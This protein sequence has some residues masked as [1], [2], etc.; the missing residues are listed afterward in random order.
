MPPAEPKK[1]ST[2][3][4]VAIVALVVVVATIAVPV[5]LILGMSG[6]SGDTS[7]YTDVTYDDSFAL[8][9]GGNFRVTAGWGYVTALEIHMNVTDGAAVDVYIMTED[10]YANTYAGSSPLAYSAV[11]F[12]EN[13]T[14]LSV[15]WNLS[16]DAT[17]TLYVV[18]DNVDN[19]LRPLDAT[20]TGNVEVEMKLVATTTYYYD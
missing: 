17:S 15:S 2:T 18:V 14:E 11:E 12:W 3:L 4:I 1:D 8:A 19:P 9:P 7:E 16:D 10:Q 5:L 20:P 6:W 13:V